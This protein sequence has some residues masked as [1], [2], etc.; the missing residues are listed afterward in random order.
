[1]TV[2]AYSTRRFV[3]INVKKIFF[4][5]KTEILLDNGEENPYNNHVACMQPSYASVLE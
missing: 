5:K 1:M 2:I 4:D 3:V